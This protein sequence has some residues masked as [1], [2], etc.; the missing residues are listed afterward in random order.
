MKARAIVRFAVLVLAIFVASCTAA[1][2]EGTGTSFL[3]IENLTASAGGDDEDSGFLLSD[4]VTGG[5]VINDSGIATLRL[6]LKD[7]GPAS[8]PTAATQNQFITI[9]RYHIRYV[10]A[11]GRNVQGVDVP[12][13]F[14]GACTVTV[15]TS[16]GS[17]AFLLV[18]HTAKREPPLAALADDRVKIETIAEITFYGKDQTGHQA[19][20]TGRILISFGDFADPA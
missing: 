2:K 6:G 17:C 19:S 5:G 16:G 3:I 7:P 12:Y 13:E 1:V 20:V 15:T 8:S 10:R 11:D 9:D 4:V 18:R 14:D